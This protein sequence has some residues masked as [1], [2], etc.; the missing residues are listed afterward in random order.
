MLDRKRAF[1]PKVTPSSSTDPNCRHK[2]AGFDPSFML[3]FP[4]VALSRMEIFQRTLWR[5]KREKDFVWSFSQQDGHVSPRPRTRTLSRYSDPWEFFSLET[6][7]IFFEATRYAVQI[8]VQT[9]QTLS[10]QGCAYQITHEPTQA[11]DIWA[12]R[13]LEDADDP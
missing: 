8:G 4:V 11:K 6:S 10:I 12:A 3:G 1:S 2:T 13:S 7:K 9:H 5:G